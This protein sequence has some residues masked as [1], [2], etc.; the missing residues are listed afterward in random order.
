V[1]FVTV[2]DAVSPALFS[3][4]PSSVI[5]AVT[6][7]VPSFSAEASMPETVVVFFLMSADAVP[8]TVV[9]PSV[10]STVTVPDSGWAGKET[11]TS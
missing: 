3:L 1:S 11:S 9:D 10:S 7:I 6:V 8:V 4:S 2:L 5:L